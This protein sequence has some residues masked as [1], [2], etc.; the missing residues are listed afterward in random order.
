MKHELN[1]FFDSIFS[2]ISLVQKVRNQIPVSKQR[3]LDLYETL[4]KFES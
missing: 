3:R 4:S 2:D 1:F